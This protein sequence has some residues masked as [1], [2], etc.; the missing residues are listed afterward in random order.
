[1]MAAMATFI[2]KRFADVL[3]RGWMALLF[4][5]VIAIIFGIFAWIEP[6][7][8]A[9]TLT[10]VFG[11]YVLFDGLLGIW[12]AILGRRGH[13]LLLLLWALV[14]VAVGFMTLV[15]PVITAVALIFYIGGWAIATGVFEIAAAIRLRKE[16]EGEWRL[17]LG[18]MLSVLF[19]A[20]L[21]LRPGLGALAFIW[22]IGS[23]A[24]VF[25]IA[26]VVFAFKVR[27]LAT[28]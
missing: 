13:W 11:A 12:S 7:T 17:I 25:G 6:R 21:L 27:S 28:A 2:E 4:R 3:S 10:L 19:G 1:M 8:S 9:R 22:L 24:L 23:Y 16:I 18:G 15:A 5:G 20:F 26:L 14:G